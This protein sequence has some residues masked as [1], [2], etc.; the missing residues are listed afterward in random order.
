MDILFQLGQQHQSDAGEEK[1]A[2]SCDNETN[3]ESLG[4]HR[5]ASSRH[6][7]S[8][9]SHFGKEECE[10]VQKNAAET[11]L[12]ISLRDISN[13]LFM[14]SILPITTST[15]RKEQVDGVEE[16]KEEKDEDNLD[17]TRH[18]ALSSITAFDIGKVLPMNL[19]DSM[20]FLANKTE[21][22]PLT[23][24]ANGKAPLFT[25]EMREKQEQSLLPLD[26]IRI[27]DPCGAC[28]KNLLTTVDDSD[29]YLRPAQSDEMSC[30]TIPNMNDA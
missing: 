1:S 3:E 17:L 15:T 12:G 6:L 7:D 9:V 10:T 29:T 27:L 23:D 21:E 4:A 20:S 8:C 22:A 30:V 2:G 26:E 5:S 16:T 28:N 13:K 18:S 14:T 24:P 19:L 25:E 11:Y